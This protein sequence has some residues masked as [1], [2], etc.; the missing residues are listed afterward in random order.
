M[1][2]I[3]LGIAIV[4]VLAGGV[5]G[6][7]IYKKSHAE[8]NEVATTTVSNPNLIEITASEGQTVLDALKANAQVDYSDSSNGVLVNA[9]N[10]IK[11]S[12]KEFWLYSVNG[13][14]GLVAADKYICKNGDVIK[15]EY[16][17]F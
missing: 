4:I 11:N 2:K 14:D 9:I 6:G 15:W 17:G 1:K 16:K 10:G 5:I 3:W 8:K 13:S 12:D 7:I